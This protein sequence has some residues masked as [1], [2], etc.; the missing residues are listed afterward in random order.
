MLEGGLRLYAEM[1]AARFA[2][3]GVPTDDTVP[4]RLLVAWHKPNYIAPD[5]ITYDQFGFRTNGG[6]ALPRDANPIV[7][8]GGSTAYGWGGADNESI[9]AVLEQRLNTPV[10]NAG[11]P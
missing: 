1:R 10:I 11:F 9:E 2:G 3:S 7:M 8:L 6:A 4:D 5:G